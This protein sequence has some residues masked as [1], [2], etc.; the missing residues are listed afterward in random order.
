MVHESDTSCD[1][2]DLSSFPGIRN[3][4]E[5]ECSMNSLIISF[6]LAVLKEMW[7]ADMKLSILHLMG[8]NKLNLEIE[9]LYLYPVERSLNQDSGCMGLVLTLSLMKSIA[10]SIL[11]N[12]LTSLGGFS[13]G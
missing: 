3:T 11:H 9:M 5:H 6:I 1:E 13:Y 7:V 10:L 2:H 8:R 12:F 4:L